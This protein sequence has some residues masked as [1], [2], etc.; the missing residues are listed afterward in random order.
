MM[1]KKMMRSTILFVVLFIGICTTTNYAYTLSNDC[2]K[3]V[4]NLFIDYQFKHF[5][6]RKN[7]LTVDNDKV[8]TITFNHKIKIDNNSYNFIYILDEQNKKVPIEL[9]NKDE[10]NIQVIP[11]KLYVY[12]KQYKLVLDKGLKG[13]NSILPKKDVKNFRIA[14]NVQA[15]SIYQKRETVDYG[16]TC[17]DDDLQNHFNDFGDTCT[18]I[19]EKLNKNDFSKVLHW[20]V[21]WNEDDIK[22]IPTFQYKPIPTLTFTRVKAGTYYIL[23]VLSGFDPKCS[24]FTL[25]QKLTIEKE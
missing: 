20:P 8:W 15:F 18:F 7:G 2:K 9:K 16:G 22:K 25:M 14:P 24:K 23:G 12:E 17:N 5:A 11:K 21:T 19:L 1:L 13:F 4:D 3:G 6:E 10:Y